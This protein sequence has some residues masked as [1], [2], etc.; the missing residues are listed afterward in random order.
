[1]VA[2]PI[3][4]KP[5]RKGRGNPKYKP[6]LLIDIYLLARKGLTD[7][8]IAE[9][10]DVN[11]VNFGEWK[12]DKPEVAYALQRG[13]SPAEGDTTGELK[14]YVYKHLSPE[15]KKYWDEI[16]EWED[17][18]DSFEKITAI[19]HKTTD[20]VR[21]QLFIHAM[22]HTIFDLSE[23]CRLVGIGRRTLESW[24]ASDSNFTALMQEL[25][26]HKK[27][28]FEKGLIDLTLMRN[29]HVVMF[30]NKTK[31][32]DRGYGEV[33]AHQHSG[34][35]KHDHKHEHKLKVEPVNLEE[36]AEHGLSI[37]CLEELTEAL[38][39]RNEAKALEEAKPVQEAAAGG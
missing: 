9:A 36:L 7:G 37:Q 8:A 3:P 31:N 12:R 25:D 23:A 30:V 32:R 6:E 18:E 28:F 21:Q 11:P 1:M 35:I 26:F 39:K 13:K 5:I 16:V 38:K 24:A 15:L 14:D 20:S 19:L 27:N 2:Q 34:E 17:H 10:L 33:F 22:F 4:Q 29:P